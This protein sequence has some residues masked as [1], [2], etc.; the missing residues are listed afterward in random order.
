MQ[1]L[2]TI[3]QGRKPKL[4]NNCKKERGNKKTSTD[5]KKRSTDKKKG[6]TDNKKKG[7]QIISKK[8]RSR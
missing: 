5:N 2:Q 6:S 4:K 7:A 8:I 1:E 3:P